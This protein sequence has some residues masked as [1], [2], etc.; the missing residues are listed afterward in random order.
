[1]DKRFWFTKKIPLV[2]GFIL[3]VLCL[4]QRGYSQG[5][6]APLYVFT[7]GDG[8][9]TPYQS[10]QMLE[11]GQ[12]YT[13]MATPAA[14]YEFSSWQPVNVFIFIQT[15]FNGGN[16][17]LPP[18]ESIDES[19]IPTNIYGADLEFTMQGMML[20][21]EGANPVISET[22]GWQANFVPVPEPAEAVVAGCGL[23]VM[24]VFRQRRK[25]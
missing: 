14:G 4:A 1:M 2:G 7:T 10:G 19:L 11:V 13:I 25:S 22:S 24:A 17:V 16:P 23:A 8:S 18:V 9:V 15:N 3:M 21:Q 6:L 12:T 20:S 5:T